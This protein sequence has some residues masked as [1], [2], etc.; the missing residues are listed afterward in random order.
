MLGGSGKTVSDLEV[1]TDL[2]QALANPDKLKAIQDDFVTREKSAKD[3]EAKANAAIQEAKD[4]AAVNSVTHNAL[5][6]WQADL[7]EKEAVYKQRQEDLNTRILNQIQSEASLAD[8]IK[9]L[10]ADKKE[11]TATKERM[12]FSIEGVRKNNEADYAQKL[13]DLRKR[14]DSVTARENEVSRREDAVV[15]QREL[16]QAFLKSVK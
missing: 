11:F 16:A 3:A 9:A 4:A 12:L 1:L 15:K 6:A 7:D 2:A 10:E 5:S 8:R 13:L 14:D